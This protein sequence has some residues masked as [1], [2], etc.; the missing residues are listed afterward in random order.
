MSCYLLK[1]LEFQLFRLRLPSIAKI[2]PKIAKDC[3]RFLKIAKDYQR[4]LKISKD[5]RRLPKMSKDFQRLP[6]IS[7]DCQR[8]PRISKDS[9][10]FSKSPRYL[11]LIFIFP[12]KKTVPIFFFSF[13][14][15]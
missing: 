12:T 2:F 11:L 5:W 13:F 8:F 10:T 6:K 1:S 7:K 4:L 14:Q 3:Q 15:N 9:K